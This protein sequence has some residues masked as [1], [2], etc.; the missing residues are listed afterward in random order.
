MVVPSASAETRVLEVV[1]TFG[2]ALHRLCRGYE[3]NLD[4][5]EELRQEILLQLWRALDGFRGEASLRT[6][7][8]RVA[9]NTAIKHVA[10]DAK[11]SP[12][13]DV[14]VDAFGAEPAT[15]AHLDRHRARQRLL[16]AIRDL[17]TSNRE[18]ALL[19]LEGLSNVDIGEV[20]GISASNVGTRLTRLRA[21][22][23]RAVGGLNVA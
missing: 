9:H 23:A 10:K 21:R 20:M 8:F 17:E 2:P 4:A 16:M 1:S 12:A 18:L 11:R 22:L 19:H 15:D 7:V 13:S 3:A 5:R 14:D 6:F